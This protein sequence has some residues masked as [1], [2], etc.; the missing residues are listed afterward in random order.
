MVGYPPRLL[1]TAR[2]NMDFT[3][4]KI[5]IEG[6]D[7]ECGFNLFIQVS[8]KDIIK[9]SWFAKLAVSPFF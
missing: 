8:G 3:S 9:I 2:T 7:R 6:L 5:H 4:P 1:I